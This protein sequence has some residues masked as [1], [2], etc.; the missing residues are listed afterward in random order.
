MAIKIYCDAC[1]A[2]IDR[3]GYSCKIHL[4]KTDSPNY[5]DRT[6][7]WCQKCQVKVRDFIR[8]LQGDLK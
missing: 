8:A 6:F 4:P 7:D 1:Q 5:S 2:E 3:M